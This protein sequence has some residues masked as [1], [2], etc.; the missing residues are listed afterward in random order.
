MNEEWLKKFFQIEPIDEKVLSNPNK[1][2]TEGGQIIYAKAEQ[3]IVGCVA[4]KHH[5]DGLIELTKMAVTA[6]FQA[7]GIGAILMTSCIKEFKRLAG[8]KLYLET[9]SSLKPAIK[10]YERFGF[11]SKPHPFQSE[12]Q[13]SDYYMEFQN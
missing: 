4:L 8:N 7:Q 12:Y 9:H 5:G 2:I 10:L 11:V 1:I 6:N 3:K 13:R